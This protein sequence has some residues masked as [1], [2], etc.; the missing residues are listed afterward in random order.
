MNDSNDTFQP[1]EAEVEVPYSVRM[2]QRKKSPSIGLFVGIIAAVAA[3]L[4]YWQVSN[5]SNSKLAP[6]AKTVLPANKAAAE[7]PVAVPKSENPILA[8]RQDEQPLDPSD[9]ESLH[10]PDVATNRLVDSEK[11]RMQEDP[12]MFVAKDSTPP[13]SSTEPETGK[14]STVTQ[15]PLETPSKVKEKNK[16]ANAKDSGQ[17]ENELFGPP[18]GALPLPGNSPDPEDLP[19]GKSKMDELV[20]QAREANTEC[21]TIERDCRPLFIEKSSLLADIAKRLPVAAAADI[22]VKDREPRLKILSQRVRFSN[23][24]YGLNDEEDKLR[25]QR[26]EAAHTRDTNIAEIKNHQ[27][28]LGQLDETLQYSFVKFKRR[29]DELNDCRK[30]W[31]EICRPHDK[32]ARADFEGAKRVTDEWLQIDNLWIDAYCWSAL[33]AYELGD[34]ALAKERIEA[35]EK[36]RIEVLRQ[37]RPLPLIEATQGLIAIQQP[38]QRAK[39][40]GMVQKAITHVKDT[41]WQ[42]PFV[43]GRAAVELGRQDAKAKAYFERALKIDPECQYAKYWL[44]HLQTTSTETRV[45]DL[46]AGIALLEST[47]SFSGEQSWRVGVALARA[48]DAANRQ[49]DAS[50]QWETTLKLVPTSER[51]KLKLK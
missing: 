34:F 27:A 50:R 30:S 5:T 21:T 17:N 6:I 37:V 51:A 18:F 39:S 29:W 44:G 12:D 22:V 35:V 1:L 24:D 42:T 48:Y 49:S 14:K 8:E 7:S 16:K 4:V 3:G 32:Y 46:D 45:R 41:D 13:P 38:G 9:Q 15:K 36:L 2:K 10:D 40:S 43:A 11:L 28:R 20:R 23:A 47:W 25:A 33:C 31:L 26:D 19:V